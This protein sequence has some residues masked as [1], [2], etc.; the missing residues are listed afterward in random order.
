MGGKS[1]K[2][3]GGVAAKNKLDMLK[4]RLAIRLSPVKGLTVTPPRGPAPT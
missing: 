4:D 1:R 2:G 3:P